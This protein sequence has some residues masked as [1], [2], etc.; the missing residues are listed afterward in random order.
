MAV[1]RLTNAIQREKIKKDKEDKGLLKKL[2]SVLIAKGIITLDD[3][4]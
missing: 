2:I 1:K 3:L 4:K